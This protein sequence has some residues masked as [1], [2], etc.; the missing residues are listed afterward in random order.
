MQFN[1][2][3]C[4]IMHF[5]H[6]NRKAKYTMNDQTLATAPTQ[7]DLGIIISDKGLPGE[8][9]ALAAKKANQVLGQINRSF[10]CRTRDIMLQVYKVFLWPHLEYGV[11]AWSPW[12]RKDIEL[13]E[14]FNIELRVE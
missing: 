7:R 4:C 11:A 2:K 5:G 8:Q 3:K 6:N 12:Q 1:V 13:L 9:S 10:T 14:K